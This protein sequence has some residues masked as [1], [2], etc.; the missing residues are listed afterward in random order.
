MSQPCVLVVATRRELPGFLQALRARGLDVLVAT[1][2]K[3]AQAAV[4]K[5]AP[6]VALISEKLPLGG[7]LRVSKDLRRHPATKEIPLVLYGL[8]PLTVAQRVR[9][10]PSAPDAT[11][12]GGV[13]ADEVASAVASALEQGRLPQIELTPRQQGGMKYSRIG[14]MLMVFGVIFSMPGLGGS[15]S[16]TGADNKSWFLLMVPLGGLVSDYATGLVDGRKKLLTWQ[17]MAAIALAAVLAVCILVWPRFFA[18]PG[19]R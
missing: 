17:G 2:H 8:K 6:S 1:S 7:A 4:A 13:S 15:P 5:Q 16:T 3:E 9:L 19:G 14:N 18:W 10:G 11:V 12:K